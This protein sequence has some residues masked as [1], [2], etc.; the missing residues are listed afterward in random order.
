MTLVYRYYDQAALECQ[1]NAR[2]TVP[3]VAPFLARYAAE[4]AR[5]RASLPCR[6]GIPYGPTEPERLDIFPAAIT[7]A[8]VFVFL[9][10]GYWRALDSADSS[11]MAECFTK[12]GACVVAVNYALAP[13]VRL[14][15]IVRQCH[16]ALTWVRGN[17][18]GFGGDPRRV[19]VAGSSAG[20]HLAAMM[21]ADGS[22]QPE[23][24]FITGAT[25]LSGLYDL[26]PVRL[27]HP[28]EWLELD[29][30]EVETLSP[31]RHPPRPRLPIVLSYAPSDTGEFKRQSECY[32][33]L[34]KARGCPVRFVPMA[35][36]NHFDIVFGLADP[37]SPLAQAV[38]ETMGL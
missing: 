12:A 24:A 32:V 6:L 26:E 16:A 38:M 2:G 22:H 19:H 37:A 17:I 10:G 34:A 7:G 1:L 20:A 28:N 33:A 27:G 31:L 18:A 15:E 13:T 14:T 21:L 4:S 11:F 29:A 8:P 3:D 23:A 30:S 25:L 35:G 36:T 5:M 9:H